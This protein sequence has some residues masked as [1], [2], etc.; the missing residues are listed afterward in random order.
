MAGSHV[1]VVAARRETRNAVRETLRPMG[2]MIDYV[3]SVEEARQFCESGMPHA[4]V[5]EA[6]LAGENFQRL[7][8]DWSAEVRTLA[9]IEIGEQGHA[10]E[11]SDMGGN[12]TSRVGRDA[13]ATA[14]PSALL[15]EL[16]R[17]A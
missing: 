8:R 14:L 6:A 1:L 3:A 17:D 15:F 4:I 12:R 11:V 9:F 2:L 5:Y 13:L 16:V 7:R 10:L